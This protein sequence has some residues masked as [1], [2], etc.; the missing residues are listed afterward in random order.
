MYQAQRFPKE[1]MKN[2]E[3]NRQKLAVSLRFVLNNVEKLNLQ[4]ERIEWVEANYLR[5]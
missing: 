3:T 2:T 5:Y 1:R 4:H